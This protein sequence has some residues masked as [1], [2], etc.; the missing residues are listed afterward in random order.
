MKRPFRALRHRGPRSSYDAVVIGAG[1]GGLVCANLLA[2]EG[3]SVLLIEQ[4]Y[5][6]G[7]YCSTFR[8]AGYTFDAATHFYPLLGNPATLTGR[9]LTE[10]GI[11]TEWV[12]MDPVDTFHL[13]DG[14]RFTVP[15]DFDAYRQKLAAHFPEQVGALEEFF[16][17]V[18][19]AYTA[20]LLYYF[21]GNRGSRLERLNHLTLAEVIDR[22]FSD[23]RLKLILTAD[24][25]HWGSP[26][27]R[28]SFV[29]DSMLRLSYFLGNYYPLRGSQAFADE[30]AWRFEERGGDILMSTRAD[31]IATEGSGGRVSA[32][33]MTTT[34][35]P[36]SGAHCVRTPVVVSNADLLLTLEGLLSREAVDQRVIE[37]TRALRPTFPCFLTH[38]GLRGVARPLLEEAQGYY[39][40]EWDS[41]GVGGD[42]LIGKIFI[43]T[44]Y[45]PGMAPDGGQIAILQKVLD[46]EVEAIEDWASH[47]AQVE[48]RLLAH[49]E[50][51]LPGIRDRIV[52]MSS[53][54][55]RTAERFT[56]NHRGA[57]L[58]WEMS[59][60]QL[61]EARPGL[62][63]PVPGLFRVGHWVAP[64]G[65]ITP[66]IVSAMRVAKLICGGLMVGGD[67]D[68]HP[69]G[70]RRLESIFGPR[71]AAGPSRNGS[72]SHGGESVSR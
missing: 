70:G 21:R 66:V 22:H 11:E 3:L 40:S 5:M 69:N 44:L 27:S 8:R 59:P 47:K 15:A 56:L 12:R 68:S 6:V 23:E 60:S 55:A 26:P 58:G 50:R 37:A 72:V 52:V 24:C 61:G 31:R 35:G 29:F 64:G 57:M 2:R 45:A 39:W 33:E 43:P 7:G 1:I 49:F 53:A 18:R 54:T 38:I 13:P 9:L 30:L 4:H 46:I 17:K 67:G 48:A 16:T 63:G 32:V 41:E 62:E 28:T 36:L 19:E 20:G 10:L 14:S 25:A 71:G 51:V 34:R 42:A 65:G